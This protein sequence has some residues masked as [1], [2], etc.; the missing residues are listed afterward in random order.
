[1]AMPEPVGENHIN[2]NIDYYNFGFVFSHYGR[3]DN[4]KRISPITF[5]KFLFFFFI[6]KSGILFYSFPLSRNTQ[7]EYVMKA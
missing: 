3:R 2:Q 5:V 7:C 1:M 6:M 4:L